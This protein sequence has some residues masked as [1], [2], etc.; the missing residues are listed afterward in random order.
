MVC[1]VSAAG[2]ALAGTVTVGVAPNAPE[3][4]TPTAVVVPPVADDDPDDELDL[5]LELHAVSMTAGTTSNA[6]RRREPKS[7]DTPFGWKSWD[8]TSKG[9]PRG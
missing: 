7:T 3:T 9:S 4:L 1:W 6:A 5:E 8:Q 2:A